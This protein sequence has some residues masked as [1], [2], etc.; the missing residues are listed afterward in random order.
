MN[1]F[2]LMSY[3]RFSTNAFRS[4]V[5]VYKHAHGYYQIHVAANRYEVDRSGLPPEPSP[6]EDNFG[7]KVA[8]RHRKVMDLVKGVEPTSIGGPL[9]GADFSEAT[10]EEAADR[11]EEIEEAGYHVPDGTIEQ[12]RA[13]T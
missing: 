13:E 4:D 6:E 12:L 1:P 2:S 5:Y 9:D 11:L 3:C 8:R 7:K 10:P